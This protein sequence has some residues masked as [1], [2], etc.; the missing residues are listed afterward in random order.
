MGHVNNAVYL[1]Y[2]E[3]ARFAYWRALW[4]AEMGDP[5]TPGVILARAEID[6]R[7]PA[8]YGEML[9]VRLSLD[10]LGRSSIRSN[11]EIVNGSGEVV[12]AGKSVL[13]VYDYA[14]NQPVA[15][16]DEVRARL[17]GS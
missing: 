7:R 10:G 13:V 17:L 5:Q 3:E 12:A 9:H 11:Y 14:A 2:M 1:T 15:I 8:R 6:Y 4:G 16:S